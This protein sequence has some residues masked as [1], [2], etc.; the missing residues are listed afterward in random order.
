MRPLPFRTKLNQEHRHQR[1]HDHDARDGPA[2]QVG[3]AAPAFGPAAQEL[4]VV[5]VKMREP[6]YFGRDLPSSPSG[7]KN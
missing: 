6:E 7:S 2:E 3:E 4:V 1:Q 5:V